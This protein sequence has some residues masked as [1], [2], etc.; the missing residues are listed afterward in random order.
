VWRY[1]VSVKPWRVADAIGKPLVLQKRKPRN[2]VTRPGLH[3]YRRFLA[4]GSPLGAY[5]DTCC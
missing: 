4:G 5:A 1:V 2:A 3:G